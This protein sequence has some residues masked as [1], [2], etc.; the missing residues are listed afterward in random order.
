ML[1]AL[2]PAELPPQFH[3]FMLIISFVLGAMVG[4]FLNVCVYR[5]PRGLSVIRPR[6]KCPG[7]DKPIAWYDNVPLVSWLVLG[8][9]CRNCGTA[10]SWQYPLV[11]AIT[12]LLFLLVYWRF[13]FVFATPVYM[14]LAAALV[15]VTFVDLTDWT[16][17]N[18]ITIPGTFIGIGLSVVGM[19]WPESGLQLSDPLWAIVG[20]VVGFAIP[21]LLDKLALL[22]LGK[23]GM[24]MG[25]AKLLAMLGAFFGVGGVL[26]DVVIASFIGS[27]VGIGLIYWNRRRG[28]AAEGGT[29][30]PF[31]PYLA[32][33]GVI[34]MFYGPQIIDAYWSYLTVPGPM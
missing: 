10:I 6:S 4:S 14:A 24:G 17:P 19:M 23:R 5:L 16:I 8:A 32:L 27:V 2:F 7:C 1:A 29:Y 12:G 31:G 13:G 11:E 33:A 15:V 34:V 25:D 30:L 22:V 28:N 9:K 26:L 21:Y 3:T 18:E 20:A